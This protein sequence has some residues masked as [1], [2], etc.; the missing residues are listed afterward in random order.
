MKAKVGLLAAGH[1]L[2]WILVN[3]PWVRVG[4]TE[5]TGA[6][7][8]PL[9]NLL[10]AISLIMIFIAAYK[11][12]ARTLWGLSGVLAWVS[13]VQLP[14]ANEETNAAV[15]GILETISG[16]RNATAAQAGVEVSVGP[17]AWI[18]FGFALLVGG[19]AVWLSFSQTQ[20]K[21]VVKEVEQGDNRSIWDEQQ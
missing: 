17:L 7:Y 12:F 13:A 14:I 8:L 5:L 9:L 19:F 1:A 2:L 11:K 10:P 20:S 15:L 18:W 6:E 16:I 3:T 4:N 21:S